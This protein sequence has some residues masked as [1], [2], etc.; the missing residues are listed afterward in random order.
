M[1]VAFAILG[2][3]LTVLYSV[4]ENALLR[5]RHDARISE[6]TL[7]AQSLLAR[8]GVEWPLAEGTRAGEWNGFSYQLAVQ[9]NSPGGGQHLTTLPTAHISATVAWPEA[10]GRRSISLSALKFSTPE[11]P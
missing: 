3:T 11:S 1:V 7:V 4:F 8:A 6:G 10:A 2:V 5:S 9:A